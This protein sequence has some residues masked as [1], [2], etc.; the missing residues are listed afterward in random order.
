MWSQAGFGNEHMMAEIKRG[1]L[2][3]YTPATALKQWLVCRQKGLALT[4]KIFYA[5]HFL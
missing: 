5:D 2:M 4:L 1:G 3:A